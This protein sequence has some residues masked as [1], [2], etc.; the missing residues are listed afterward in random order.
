MARLILKREFRRDLPAYMVDQVDDLVQETC[1]E[2]VRQWQSFRGKTVKTYAAWMHSIA[3]GKLNDWWR[4]FN[5]SVP[6]LSVEDAYS[7]LERLPA[8]DLTGSN[9]FRN[10]EE[11]QRAAEAIARLPAHESELLRLHFLEE[12]AWEEIAKRTGRTVGA[13]KMLLGRVVRRLGRDLGVNLSL[14]T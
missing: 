8:S 3:R 5:H 11:Q 13:A 1:L 7:L 14:E 2:I 4:R 9:L 10:K 12:L 6:V